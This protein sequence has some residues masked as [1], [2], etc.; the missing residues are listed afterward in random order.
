MAE[1]LGEPLRRVDLSRPAGDESARQ[2]AIKQIERRRRFWVHANVGTVSI[3]LIAVVW[4]TSGY[5]SAGGWPTQGFSQ[6]SGTHDVWNYG[7]IYPLVVWVLTIGGDAW[8]TFSRK[9]ITESEI[10]REMERQAGTA[11]ARE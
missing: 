2:K 1:L 7:I 9:P 3:V 11:D 5:H 8:R 10:R 6:S 4:A